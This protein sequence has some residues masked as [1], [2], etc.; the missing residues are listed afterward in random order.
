[1]NPMQKAARANGR[2]PHGSSPTPSARI[3]NLRWGGSNIPW[4]LTSGHYPHHHHLGG[5]EEQ[6][7]GRMKR[8][9]IQLDCKNCEEAWWNT[10]RSSADC[11]TLLCPITRE[12]EDEVVTARQFHKA[13]VWSY[14]MPGWDE[15][16]LYEPR[17]L[18]MEYPAKE[19]M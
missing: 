9:L 6:G 17:P 5:N 2:N 18:L 7:N 3:H 13:T 14:A 11:P 12:C 4:S 15:D 1:M 10:A 16:S 19:A 8:H